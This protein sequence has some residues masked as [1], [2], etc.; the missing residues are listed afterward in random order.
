M[1]KNMNVI[2]NFLLDESGEMVDELSHFIIG[3]ML[4]MLAASIASTYFSGIHSVFAKASML[5]S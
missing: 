2:L 5:Y 1:V 4:A 3:G